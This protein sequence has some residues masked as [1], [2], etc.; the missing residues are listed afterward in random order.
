MAKPFGGRPA[1]AHRFS[2]GLKAGGVGRRR[3]EPEAP[4]GNRS[5]RQLISTAPKAGTKI[6]TFQTNETPGGTMRVTFW[7]DD[8][9]PKGWTTGELAPTHWMPLPGC[10]CQFRPTP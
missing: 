10:P 8:T 4:K 5:P 9:V 1:G 2:G 6:L 7:R 3:Q